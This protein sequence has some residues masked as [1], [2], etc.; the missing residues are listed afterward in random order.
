MILIV[1][2]VTFLW[3]VIIMTPS[4]PSGYKD[5]P[6]IKFESFEK[7]YS[8]NPDR[9]ELKDP[10]VSCRI[11]NDRKHEPYGGLFY[12]YKLEKFRFS[13]FDYKKYKKFLKKLELNKLENKHM[14]STSKMLSMVK[15]D[16]ANMEELAQ[17]QKQQALDNFNNI[18]NNLGG[19]K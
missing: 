14:E 8:I 10:Y 3:V 19:I 5:L 13:R 1:L 15:K 6:I 4:Y 12:S 11:D 7:F 9:W 18:L 2:I 17:Q 16:I